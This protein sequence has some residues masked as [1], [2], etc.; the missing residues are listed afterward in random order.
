MSNPEVPRMPPAPRWDPDSG[1]NPF[2][3]IVA[4]APAVRDQRNDV[5]SQ[6]MA[7]ARHE[8][9]LSANLSKPK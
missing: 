6:A 7:K 3:W 4:T 5:M 2:R 9:R 8:R 1:E